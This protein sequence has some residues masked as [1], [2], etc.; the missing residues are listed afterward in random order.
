M[1]VWGRLIMWLLK[2]WTFRMA[3]AMTQ[4][5]EGLAS[6]VTLCLW[7]PRLTEVATR[8]FSDFVRSNPFPE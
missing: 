7:C 3:V 4:V 5:I 6:L 8:R 1:D 2:I